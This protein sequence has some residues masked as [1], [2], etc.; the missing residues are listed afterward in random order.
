LVQLPSH[1][2]VQLPPTHVS[3]HVAPAA[4]VSVHEPPVHDAVH[5]LPFSHVVLQ[6]L[7]VHEVL[8]LA[9]SRQTVEQEPKVQLESHASPALQSHVLPEHSRGVS[10]PDEV[11]EPE[12]DAP[13]DQ[14]YTQAGEVMATTSA[15]TESAATFAGRRSTDV[16]IT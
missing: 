12:P 15:A 6:P 1:V 3:S 9:P 8:Q 4:H 2:A 13:V 11:D 5:V 10:P 16:I 7:P 14:S